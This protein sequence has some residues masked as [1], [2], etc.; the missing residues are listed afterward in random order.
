MAERLTCLRPHNTL[1]V[2]SYAAA[3]VMLFLQSMAGMTEQVRASDGAARPQVELVMV[4]ARGCAW[5]IHWLKQ[6]GP[7]YPKTEQGRRAPLKRI[8][9]RDVASLGL[10]LSSPVT[11]TPTFVLIANGGEIGRIIG[12]PGDEFFWG[13]LD[14]LLQ[15]LPPEPPKSLEHGEAAGLR[16]AILPV[17]PAARQNAVGRNVQFQRNGS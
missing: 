14:E 5:C 7:A 3:L 6:I 15:K 4:E 12:H 9:I 2:A 8:D 11:M 1:A 17:G 10:S 13:L 16:D